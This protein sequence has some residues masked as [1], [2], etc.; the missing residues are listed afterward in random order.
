[1]KKL[2]PNRN[3]K[4][5][6][7]TALSV[8]AVACF[9]TIAQAQS[10]YI[11]RSKQ[12][13]LWNDYSTWERASISTPTVFNPL[14]S[15]QPVPNRT[16]GDIEI[17]DTHTVTYDYPNNVDQI[18][19]KPGGVLELPAGKSISL[20]VA[21]STDRIVVQGLNG[22]QGVLR[23]LGGTFAF[24]NG[25]SAVT[26]TIEVGAYGKYEHAYSNTVGYIPPATWHTNSEIEFK[27]SG[28]FST[29]LLADYQ[30]RGFDQV[31]GNVKWNTPANTNN[32]DLKGVIT[33]VKGNFEVVSTGNSASG[34]SGSALILSTSGTHNL[35]IGKNLIVSGAKSDL[36]FSTQGAPAG[37]A[38]NLTIGEGMQISNSGA[39]RN[40]TVATPLN[41]QFTGSGNLQNSA[42]S[43]NMNFEIAPAANLTLTNDF[44]VG[45]ATANFVVN[46]TLS[47]GAYTLK[48]N[49]SFILAD[50][51]NLNIGSPNGISATGLT[52][53]IQVGGNRNFGTLANYAYNGTALQVT[54][55]GLPA[56]VS[57]LIINNPSG[58]TLSAPVSITS[59]L[60][61]LEG[62]IHTSAANVLAVANT[63]KVQMPAAEKVSYVNGP[64]AQTI[65]TQATTTLNFPVGKNGNFRPV[66]L[67]ITQ[68]NNTVTTYTAEQFEGAYQ[69]TRSLPSTINKV[70]SVR[71]FR[72]TQSP[73]ATLNEGLVTL[74]YGADDGVT[75]PNMLSIAKSNGPA[76]WMDLDGTAAYDALPAAGSVVGFFTD[77]SD[78]ILAN[79]QGGANPLP[80]ELLSFTA[81]AQNTAVQLNWATASEKNAARFE[82][83]RSFNG[84]TF[85]KI[86][87]VQAAG[88]SQLE[89]R[90]AFT[91]QNSKGELV[92]YR[93][94]QVDTDGTFAYSAIVSVRL[95][96]AARNFVV[97]PNPAHQE[98]SVSVNAPGLVKITN[99][100]GQVVL[101]KK[102]EP[103]AI[104]TL[105]IGHLKPGIYQISQETATGTTVQK[106]LKN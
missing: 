48:G 52:G 88:N 14:L 16:A 95:E 63:G 102:M 105:T 66:T 75:A 1:M 10:G 54:G 2:L 57:E 13:G 23:N 97:F 25:T 35:T 80:V 20:Y 22:K 37:G 104:Q 32:L 69:T 3:F 38:L 6:L 91:D 67:E 73:A 45:S 28:S 47:T 64:L 62:V 33:Q 60:R 30:A 99:V 5:A 87:T 34:T 44:M 15:G 81:K 98:L 100:L 90:Y 9:T 83:E 106:F 27:M 92:Y 59:R 61:M 76:A 96:K 56:S 46:G 43:L 65:A 41:V 18:I 42:A 4:P 93:L 26:S 77:F 79:K 74:S 39:F 85:E 31:F 101:T 86:R 29:L 7:K 17:S 12:T 11:Y 103:S 84:A 72:I 8:L 50:A 53:N 68:N 58:L 36:V 24:T 89:K 49:G 78:F 55:T 71:Y 40:N 51:A 19:I 94:K 70:S 21:P 82:I